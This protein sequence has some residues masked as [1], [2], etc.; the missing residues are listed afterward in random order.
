MQGILGNG[1]AWESLANIVITNH[2]TEKAVPMFY[3]IA[4]WLPPAPWVTNVSAQA[5]L[6]LVIDRSPDPGFVMLDVRTPAE[7]NARHIKKAL[8]VDFYSASFEDNL[9]LLDRNKT[10]LV[11]CASGNRS[12][13]AVEVMQRQA[14]MQVYNMTQGFSTFAALAGAAAFL[15]P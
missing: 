4:C 9:K 7:Y 1:I 5:A 15:E 14:F 6:N 12:R 10:C 3:R 2:V 8:N 11:Y 13:Q